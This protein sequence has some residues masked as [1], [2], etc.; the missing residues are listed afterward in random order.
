M[1][2][3]Y[4]NNNSVPPIETVAYGQP[5]VPHITTTPVVKSHNI[6]YHQQ[7]QQH[8]QQDQN[9]TFIDNNMTTS[10][11]MDID[12][13]DHVTAATSNHG[14]MVAM[15]PTF[16]N[17]QSIYSPSMNSVTT[18]SSVMMM[19][20]L[21]PISP[22][23]MMSPTAHLMSHGNNPMVILFFLSCLFCLKIMIDN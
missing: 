4:N 2:P 17:M 10:T 3:T 7:H 21:S 11:T 22:I 5:Y 12:Y 1:A 14:N 15:D 13:F 23:N 18:N 19:D 20:T 8:Q 9:L 6:M 16:N